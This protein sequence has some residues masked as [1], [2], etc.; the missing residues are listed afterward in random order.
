MAIPIGSAFAGAG[1]TLLLVTAFGSVD[2]DRTPV[3]DAGLEPESSEASAVVNRLAPS[4]VAITASDHS[5]LR[6]GSGIVVRPRG[7]I[8]TNARLVGAATAVDVLTIDGERVQAE[9]V[10][11]D[12]AADVAL[13]RIDRAL[14]AAPV[15]PGMAG[16][17]QPIYAVGADRTGRA[18]PRV[19]RGIISST[20]GLVSTPTGP[21]M[22]GL[23][24][25]D[26]L[27]DHEWAGGALVDT[28]GRVLGILFAPTIES[29]RTFALPISFAADIAGR[30]RVDGNVAHGRLGVTGLDTAAGAVVWAVLDDPAAG[31]LAPGDIITTV[32]GR[33]VDT[34]AE[35]TAVVRRSWPSELIVIEVRRGDRTISMR[36]RLG[37]DL[38]ATP[39]PP[40]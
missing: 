37:S 1:A 27:A 5:G 39:T 38:A 30:L 32:A 3:A 34:M 22:S 2:L 11:I 28:E 33:R 14:V 13:V 12:R 40:G 4:I 35:V 19:S 29:R 31:R 6:R 10:G 36:I 24:E 23:V 7:E 25:I 21:A 18:T 9:V 16:I 17:G 15:A 26:T 8:L 20:D